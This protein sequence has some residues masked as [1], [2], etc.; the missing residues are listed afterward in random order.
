MYCSECNLRVSDDTILICPVCQGPLQLETDDGEKSA[1]PGL[2][3]EPPVSGEQKVDSEGKLDDCTKDAL[4]FDPEKFGL[5]S[6]LEK[7]A[8]EGVDD[9]R[10]L[11]DLWE[12]EDIDADL[13]E[14]F[15]EAFRLESADLKPVETDAFEL[16]KSVKTTSDLF[17][18]NYSAKQK[19][20]WLSLLVF[21]GLIVAAGG[22][23]FYLQN[24]GV[25]SE[26]Q[27]SEKTESSGLVES[28]VKDERL[29]VSG[30]AAKEATDPAAEQGVIN[31]EVPEPVTV[32]PINDSQPVSEL[33]L[34]HESGVVGQIEAGSTEAQA[35]VADPQPEVETSD[36]SVAG[37]VD[38]L[39][40][41]QALSKVNSTRIVE[42]DKNAV[43]KRADS[44]AP[45]KILA[46]PT[47][48]KESAPVKVDK[49]EIDKIKA[50]TSP[51]T[52]PTDTRYVVQI[53][54]FRSEEGALRQLAM[55]QQKG[56][57]AYRV[58]A[59][60]GGKGVWQRVFVPGGALKSDAL[61][62][63]EKLKTL[64]PREKSLIRKLKK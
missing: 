12:K 23:W 6:S 19:N 2:V 47:P 62:V 14:V 51:K 10:I 38:P 29:Y 40:E 9:I 20:S 60:L 63:Q 61:P 30:K 57:A 59:D 37:Q 27:V 41:S 13:D 7:D 55:L 48:I 42:A 24:R 52:A 54:S 46:E 15:S 3:N 43:S 39:P 16:N 64:F 33:A 28:Q 31:A 45:K 56:F 22:G 25:K 8:E 49:V 50:I 4:D 5:K 36:R 17:S 1:S 53:G 35:V 11:A 58:E 26:T 34:A 21:V 18:D 44:A 32:E